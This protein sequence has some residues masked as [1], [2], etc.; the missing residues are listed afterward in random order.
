MVSTTPPDA[1]QLASPDRAWSG[2]TGTK[3]RIVE[4]ALQT[5]KTKGFAGASSRAIAGEGDFNQALIFYHFGSVRNALLAVLDLISERRM[6][7]YGPAFEEA[8]TATDL[9]RLA[10]TIHADDLERG[11][12]MVLGEMVRAAPPIPASGPRWRRASSR[13][14]TSCS[15]SSSSSWPARRCNCSRP[16]GPRV[17]AGRPLFRRGHAQPPAG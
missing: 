8:L 5:L 9:A 6:T 7:A 2:L 1:A 14:S 16:P 13:G 12:I 17:R 15:A 4:A 10:Q 11:Y 3:L